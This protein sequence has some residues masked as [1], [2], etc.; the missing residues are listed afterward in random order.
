MS[1]ARIAK[2]TAAL[3]VRQIF[4]LGINLYT[5][6]ALIS[7]LGIDD[8]GLNN[9]ITSV[10]T[11]ASFVTGA[12]GMI[13]QRYLAF[14]IG[15][16]DEQSQKRYHDACL[17][18]CI[19]VSAIVLAG[20]ETIGAWFV[21]AHL[22][23]P[24]ERLLAAQL[25]FQFAVA[26]FI[27]GIFSSFYSSIIL[28]HEDMHIFALF[29]VAGA[30]L[31][32]TAV[33]MLG[34]F[35]TDVLVTY[36]ALLAIVSFFMMLAGWFFCSRRYVECQIGPISCKISTLREMLSFSGWTIFGQITTISRNQAVTI[37]INQTFNPATVAA[38]ALS[39]SISTQ[40]L[41][42]SSNFSAA[43]HPPI[44]KA[45]SAGDTE[46]MFN[47][48]YFGSKLSF[49]LSLMVTLPIIATAPGI[50]TFW[51]QTYPDE[52][53]LFTRL[54]LLENTILAISLPLM[55]AVRAAGKMKLYELSL[56]SLQLLVLILS[57][58]LVKSGYPAYSVY[59]VA[60]G[61]N[62][63]MFV[64]R[65]FIASSLTGLPAIVYLRTV[66][67][68][69]LLV[70]VVSSICTLAIVYIAPGVEHLT[71]NL[72]T[73]G[74]TVLLVVLPGLVIFLIGL[75]SIERHKL[76]S[77]IRRRLAKAGTRR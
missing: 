20:L 52:T 43:L 60:I 18:L 7:A 70:T 55:T 56:G 37:L 77:L 67:L 17:F 28:A 31:R 48:I 25:L 58:L 13:S 22:V 42:F 63:A 34:I 76:N 29:S 44:I 33:L 69:I 6:R 27:I 62:L 38:R 49:F 41:T 5:I 71:P 35:S 10:V 64:A 15:Q 61:I 73:V 72:T 53:V 2:N 23:V 36:G 66:V 3:F 30:V 40:V 50:L 9:V 32:L 59:L 11:I 1:S 54:A 75:T 51:L 21:S 16:G 4:I 46:Q 47:L 19:F 14:S 74:A 68:P 39:V 65:L 12:L 24:Q 57:W 8:F 26:T 45:Y